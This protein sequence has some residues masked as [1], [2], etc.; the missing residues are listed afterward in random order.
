ML[1]LS[2]KFIK[3]G[4]IIVRKKG[5]GSEKEVIDGEGGTGEATD[6]ADEGA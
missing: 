1:L 6:E 5:L 3:K 4:D 2:G